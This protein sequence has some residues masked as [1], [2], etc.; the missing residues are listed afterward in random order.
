M[1][2]DSAETLAFQ[3]VAKRQPVEWFRRD[4]TVEIPADRIDDPDILYEFA[5]KLVQRNPA[6]SQSYQQ[7]NGLGYEYSYPRTSP[8]SASMPNG[9]PTATGATASS[10]TNGTS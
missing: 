3:G 4:Y 6:I 8:S 7:V 2:Q 10:H 9:W 5:R 1:T